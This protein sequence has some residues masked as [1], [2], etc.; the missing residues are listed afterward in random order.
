MTKTAIFENSR[1]RTAAILTI[2]VSPYRSHE[3]SDFD[4]IWYANTNFHSE[5]GHLTKRSK[6]CKFKMAD[7]RHIENRLL[8]I[9]R[10]RFGRLMRN[11]DQ[12]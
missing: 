7:E 2:A 3:L 6:F 4:Q 10:H 1:W 9:S 8:P 11:V 12:R 5:H